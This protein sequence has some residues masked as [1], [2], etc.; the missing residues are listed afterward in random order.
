MK[1]RHELCGAMLESYFK[2]TEIDKQKCWREIE[3]ILGEDAPVAPA[4][5]N[6]N[7]NE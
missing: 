7:N 6:N 3:K 1:I 5:I 2:Q 4:N